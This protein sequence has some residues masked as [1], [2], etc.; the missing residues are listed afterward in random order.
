MDIIALRALLSASFTISYG[1]SQS[2][3]PLA[4]SD[5]RISQLMTTSVSRKH[6][7]SSSGYSS[8]FPNM[9]FLRSLINSVE[10]FPGGSIPSYLP[11]RSS[12]IFFEDSEGRDRDFMELTASLSVVDMV[13]TSLEGRLA[14]EVD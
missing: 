3:L 8:T 5:S 1:A 12:E 9:V 2:G 14:K 4:V 13:N 11:R 7:F 6:C 10:D